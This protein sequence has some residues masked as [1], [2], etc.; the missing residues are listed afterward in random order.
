MDKPVARLIKRKRERAQINK[1]RSEKGKVT[2]GIAKIH[3]HMDTKGGKG[4]N[5][6]EL[7]WEI[8]IDI[9][10]LLCIK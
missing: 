5:W 6:D 9:Y 2:T 8:G 1:I 3:K 10:T 4:L 7:N